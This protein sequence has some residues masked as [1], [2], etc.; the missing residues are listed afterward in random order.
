[1]AQSS[2]SEPVMIHAPGGNGH[3]EAVAPR[4]AAPSASGGNPRTKLAVTVER[5]DADAPWTNEQFADLISRPLSGPQLAEIP[6]V[7]RSLAV[8]APVQLPD[9][10]QA[11]Q[12]GPYMKRP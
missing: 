8:Y 10:Y 9:E 3:A 2:P 6:G 12:A 1:M 11:W 4:A 7:A 5:R